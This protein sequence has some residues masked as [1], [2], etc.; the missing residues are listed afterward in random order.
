[1]T[2]YAVEFFE[3]AGMGVTTAFNFGVIVNAMNLIGCFIDFFLMARFG[4]RPLI[5][6]GLSILGVMLLLIGIFGSI[7]SN[8]ATLNGVGACCAIVSGK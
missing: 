4:R 8:N 5:I 3:D 7:P 1:M 6:V 2:A